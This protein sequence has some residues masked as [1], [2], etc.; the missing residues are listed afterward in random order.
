MRVTKVKPTS[1]ETLLLAIQASNADIKADIKTMGDAIHSDIDAVNTMLD[2]VNV[3]INV[4]ID[5]LSERLDE[6]ELVIS[7]MQI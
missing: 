3:S 4:R 7:K 1:L 2:A 6:D 5:H